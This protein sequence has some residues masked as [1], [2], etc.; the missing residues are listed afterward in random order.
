MYSFHPSIGPLI[1]HGRSRKN[2]PSLRKAWTRALPTAAI[3]MLFAL[4]AAGQPIQS[5]ASPGSNRVTFSQSFK[6]VA[7]IAGAALVRGEL[8]PGEAQTT[9]DFSVALEM[10]NFAEL[11]NRV[12]RAEII[13]LDEIAS[14]YY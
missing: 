1:V 11:Q 8:A 2:C 12:A 7:T 13:S 10:H 4:S 3:V 9:L 14:K 5:G 6:E